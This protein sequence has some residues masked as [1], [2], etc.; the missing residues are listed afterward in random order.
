[1]AARDRA[2]LDDAAKKR[3]RLRLTDKHY[4][5]AQIVRADDKMLVALYLT[6][7]TGSWAPTLQLRGPATEY[8]A[9]YLKQIEDLWAAGLEVSDDDIQQLLLSVEKIQN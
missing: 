9:A 8:F 6:T 5:L 1:M 2:A 3:F 7:K 4:H